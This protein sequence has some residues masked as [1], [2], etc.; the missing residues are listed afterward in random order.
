MKI[1]GD[2]AL[3]GGRGSMAYAPRQTV[4]IA[5]GRDFPIA[6]AQLFGNVR[7]DFSVEQDDSRRL[8][9]MP[10]GDCR[11]SQLHAGIHTVH[12]GRVAARSFDPDSVKLILQSE[13]H[14]VIEQS[15]TRSP[16]RD[17]VPV[18]YDPTRPYR[19]VNA[20]PVRLLMLQLPRARFSQLMLQRLVA[21]LLPGGSGVTPILLALMQSTFAEAHGAS[22]A[23]RASVGSAMI[24]LV[25]GMIEDG[26]QP[27]TQ[28]RPLDALLE[29]VKE[30]IANNLSRPDL[31][32]ALIARRMGCSSRY[33]FR[34]FELEGRTPADYLWA[35]RL[36]KAYEDLQ[37]ATEKPRSISDIA[38]SRGFSSTAHFSRVFRDRYGMTPRDCRR[39]Y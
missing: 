1:A 25:R 7:L 28:R 21:P 23:T 5:T 35:L 14:S 34:A 32:I 10:L 12:G 20:T 16:I 22:A 26:P 30:F 37:S 4:R 24:E 38:F 13:G 2:I 31:S 36:E 19:L 6:A 11:L 17:D 9:S 29:R 8:V 39:G 3:H 33:V 18:L 15:G 27:D